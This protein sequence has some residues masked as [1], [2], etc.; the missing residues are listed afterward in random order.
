MHLA[1]LLS[2]FPLCIRNFALS[3][4]PASFCDRILLCH[5][6]AQAGLEFETLLPL[7]P[8]GLGRRNTVRPSDTFALVPVHELPC[9]IP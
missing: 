1:S 6:V 7:S 9:N 8:V 2:L 5:Q 3:H 4:I